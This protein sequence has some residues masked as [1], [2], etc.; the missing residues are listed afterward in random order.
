M[1][2]VLQRVQ[3]ASVMVDGEKIAAIG[4]GLL[5]LLGI[6]AQDGRPE[7]DYLAEK[8]VNLRIFED[9]AGKTN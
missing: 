2:I 5:I 1:R 7:A 8:C 4:R 6:G 3:N 9:N